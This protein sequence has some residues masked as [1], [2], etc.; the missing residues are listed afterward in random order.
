MNWRYPIA[1]L[2]AAAFSWRSPGGPLR[3]LWRG[4]KLIFKPGPKV[5]PIVYLSRIA[6]C[7][8]CPIYYKPL[9]TC[10][11][12]LRD[13][14]LGC[15]CFM[16]AKAKLRDAECWLREEDY[17][18]EYGWPETPAGSNPEQGGS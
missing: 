18:T 16:P 10:G 3:R 4:A 9:R 11:T 2:L 1:V 14:H 12:P 15:W 8:A 17:E 7:Y 6:C 13:A 5:K